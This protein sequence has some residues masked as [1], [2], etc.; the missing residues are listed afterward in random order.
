MRTITIE[1][2]AK[3]RSVKPQARLSRA[4]QPRYKFW[5]WPIWSN[6]KFQVGVGVAAGLIFILSLGLY[7][8]VKPVYDQSMVV[9]AKAN[10]LK[11]A[12][13]DQDLASINQQ[14]PEL[15]QEIVVLDQ[16]LDNY[17]FVRSIPG[18]A[19]YYND[20][21]HAL[22]AAEQGL[23]GGQ[24]LVKAIM[25]YG[26][27]LGFKTSRTATTIKPKDNEEKVAQL[28]LLMPAIL[29]SL[30]QA[31]TNFEVVKQEIEAIDPQRYPGQIAGVDLR[32]TIT[33]VRS[34]VLSL[35]QGMTNARPIL[36]ILP[37]ILGANQ[38]KHYL[39]LFQNDKELRPTGGFLSSTSF[40]T[41]TNGRFE[42]APSEDIYTLDQGRA[43][44]PVPWPMTAYNNARAL[45]LRD[46][47]WSPDFAESMEDF[48]LYY[49]RGNNP[50]IDGIIAVDTQFVEEL[51]RM[52][53]P[54]TV[55][56]YRE[57][58]SAEPIDVNGTKI[59][60][61]VYQLE[62]IAQKMGLG[63]ER[64]G[65]IGDLM[66]LIIEKVMSEPATKW[67]DYLTM[68]LKVGQEKNVLLNFHDKR[69]QQLAEQH[70]FAG[71][72]DKPVA[73]QD[74][75]HI[76]DANL[77]GLKT[78]FYLKQKTKQDITVASDGTVTKKVTITYT[79]TGK[80]DG[81]I[82]ATA[83]NYTRVYVPKGSTLI[84]SSG[85][86]QRVNTTTDLDYT[87]F[88]NFTT[89]KALASQTM[90]FEYKLPFKVTTDQ[91]KMLIQKQAGAQNWTY[92]TV[93]NG[94][95]SDIILDR[96]HQLQIGL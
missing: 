56:G 42:V 92:T 26:D 47:N 51:M 52:T 2:T 55:P 31:S 74:Y 72:I 9:M 8:L 91:Y 81:W 76:N 45:Y 67:P 40:I 83:R 64:K 13:S 48:E 15:Q 61:V 96:D 7:L 18:L 23:A 87:V 88:D 37:D 94:K 63:E 29:P 82:S 75:L 39:L 20:A 90:T 57:P 28:V 54:I 10:Q 34:Q 6:R 22:T 71:R 79:N 12:A 30:D 38:E 59:P 41:F 80:F 58:F 49:N 14:L 89:V 32:Q 5:T 62:I 93:I 43:F 68:V 50:A 70:N 78:N 36:E 44:L 24:I 46:T 85:G 3:K 19:N 1:S 27:L 65:V 16:Q 35:Q 25:P 60:Q 84:K 66:Q 73:N 69:A 53:G 17:S 95:S 4:K 86:Q 11:Q 21:Q 77:A 33:E